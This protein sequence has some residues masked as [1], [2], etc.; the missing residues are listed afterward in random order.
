MSESKSFFQHLKE[1]MPVFSG[2][3]GIVVIFAAVAGIIIIP[4]RVTSI[5]EHDR[6]QDN[7]LTAIEADA[8]Q[9]RELLASV[10]ATVL[11][12]DQRAKRIEE[13]LLGNKMNH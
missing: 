5:E 7:R 6:S 1:V 11:Q 9:R 4:Y 10:A 3:N 13:A 12:I 8:A 2:G